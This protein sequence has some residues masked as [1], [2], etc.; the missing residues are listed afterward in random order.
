MEIKLNKIK[1]SFTKI[2]DIR[3]AVI[4]IFNTYYSNLFRF[5]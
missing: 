3:V 1:H 5:N 4:N 2:K